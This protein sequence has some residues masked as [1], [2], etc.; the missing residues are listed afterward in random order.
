[1]HLLY[2]DDSG[3]M[4]N[5]Q[6]KH[7]I[8]AGV[9]VFERLPYWFS[10]HLDVFAR[11]LRPQDYNELEFRGVDMFAGRK[12]WRKIDKS[13]RLATYENVLRILG[14]SHQL[15]LFGAAIHKATISPEDPM[16]YA[17]EQLISRF[18]QFLGRLHKTGDTQR[19]IIILDKSSYETSLQSLAREFRKDGH[20]WGHLHNISE[21][22]LFVD[23]RATR[24]I[25]WADLIA[26][27]LR[28]YYEHGTA[29]YFDQISHLFDREGGV[30]HG[31]LH[32]VDLRHGCNCLI[33]RQKAV[34]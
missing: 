8:L 25:Q 28:Q 20:R 26:Y 19:G 18:D 27:A 10:Q 23:S 31:L 5:P 15:R 14:T 17:F 29:K 21:T 24:M 33:C 30:I 34:R 12:G 11:Q 1:M 3:S 16:E 22:P 6:D 9:A 7:I 2:L 4:G 13:S 32:R